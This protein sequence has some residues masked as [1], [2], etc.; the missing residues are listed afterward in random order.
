MT[1]NPESQTPPY[2]LTQVMD[3][4][5][6]GAELGRNRGQELRAWPE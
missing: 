6:W 5:E 2:I 4:N 3:S 1:L